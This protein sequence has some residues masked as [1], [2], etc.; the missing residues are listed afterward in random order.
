VA[1][2]WVLKTLA[3]EVPEGQEG[4]GP[5]GTISGIP[6]DMDIDYLV[7]ALGQLAEVTGEALDKVQVPPSEFTLEGHVAFQV[8]GGAPVVL[9]FGVE[10]GI[11]VSMTWNFEKTI[12]ETVPHPFGPRHT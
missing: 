10:A 3:Y 1:D 7:A 11:S 8:T 6:V 4:F 9:Q 5:D 12:T 2:K